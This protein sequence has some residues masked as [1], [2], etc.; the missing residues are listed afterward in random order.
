LFDI[1]Y[2]S[3]GRSR[4]FAHLP[5]L[6]LPTRF[7]RGRLREWTRR[8]TAPRKRAMVETRLQTM[9][10]RATANESKRTRR[11]RAG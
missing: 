5:E 4:L 2:L 8:I 10:Q 11:R 1:A 9:L 3:G 6:E 7:H